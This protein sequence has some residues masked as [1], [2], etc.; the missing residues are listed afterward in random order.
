MPYS[1]IT[2]TTSTFN[3]RAKGT[4]VKSTVTYGA[5]EDEL[6]LRP[7]VNKKNPSFGLVRTKQVDFVSGS[8]TI[9]LGANITLNISVPSTGFPVAD[10][11]VMLTEIA[12]FVTPAT[13]SRLLQ[14]EA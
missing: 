6:K 12:E 7:N 11:D 13:L 9:R 4:Y 1:P 10:L 2:T 14:G 5:P 8:T 3:E